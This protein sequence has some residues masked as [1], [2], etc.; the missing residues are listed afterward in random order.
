MLTFCF[1]TIMVVGQVDKVHIAMSEGDAALIAS[2]FDR[3]VEY[4]LKNRINIIPAKE[5]RERLERFFRENKPISY[6]N[7]HQ[8][9]STG[10]AKYTIGE[11]QTST[12]VYR[13]YIYFE[14][15]R[16]NLKIREFR[17]DEEKI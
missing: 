7:I 13:I 1:L 9:S 3:I 15:E 11:L 2:H 5:A 16:K 10:G 4:T 12:G 14:D 17:I 6:K 8:G